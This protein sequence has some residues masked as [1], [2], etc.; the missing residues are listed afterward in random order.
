MLSPVFD[1]FVKESPICV[2]ARVLMERVF[3]PEQLDKWFEQVAEEQYT[4]DLLFSTIFD[5]MSVVVCG[6]RKSVHAAYQASKEDICVSVTSVYNKLNGIEV[7]TSAELVRYAAGEMKEIIEK[8]GGANPPILD[9]FRVKLLDG[10]CI[11]SS[12]HRIEELR[13]LSAGALPGKSLVVFDPSLRM[14]IDVFPCEDGHAQERSLLSDVLATVEALDLWIAD[15][16]FCTRKFLFGIKQRA[17]FFVIREHKKLPWRPLTKEKFIG[18]IETGKVFEQ[19]IIVIDELENEHEF[20]RI[21]VRLDKATR[22]GDSDIYIITNLSKKAVNAKEIARLYRCRWTIETAFQE[23]ESHLNSE[24]NTL[25]YPPAALFAFCIALIA[26][27]IFSVVKAALASVHGIDTVENKISGYYI[28][29]EISGTYRGMMIAIPHEDW[30][31]FRQYTNSDLIKI[32]KQLSANVR[33]SAFLK[34]PRGPKRKPINRI[35]DPSHH[36]V[37]TARIIADRS[38]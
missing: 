25:G 8:L 37:S 12:E 14:P 34:H 36:H 31:A 10:N 19:T 35:S 29:D 24:I 4:R 30:I 15:R 33:L 9:D 20:R 27:M 32:L 22:D 21:H 7:N 6:T 2:M 28:A 26:Y 38:S 13:S 17:A 11:E 18:R 5:I 23:L 3:N 1:R 16:N